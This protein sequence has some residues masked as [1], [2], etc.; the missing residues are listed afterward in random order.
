VCLQALH[1]NLSLGRACVVRPNHRPLLGDTHL[2]L[3]PGGSWPP[4][5]ARCRARP[6]APAAASDAHQPTSVHGEGP[7]TAADGG[8]VPLDFSPFS[9]SGAIATATT[10]AAASTAVPA[11]PTPFG[12]SGG[13]GSGG[14]AKKD[15]TDIGALWGLFVLSLSYLHHSTCGFALPAL[16]PIISGD[17]LLSDSQGALLTAGYT[18]LYA[19]TLV[20]VGLLADRTDRPRLLAGG[21]ALWSLL[22]IAASRTGSF[23]ELL[24]TRVGFAAAQATQNPICFGLIPELFPRNKTTAMAVYNS[25]IYVGRALSFAG[26]ILAGQLGVPQVRVAPTP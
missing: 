23:G 22:T 16:L 10:N 5:I 19:L 9:E 14:G 24:A 1:I 13:G 12:D 6:A 18:I 11:P 25:A 26:L 2:Q 17:L 20:P 15:F 7:A 3:Q 8:Y 4:L 21:V